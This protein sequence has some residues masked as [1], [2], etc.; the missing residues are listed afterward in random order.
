MDYLTQYYK[1]RS[2]QLQEEL[3]KLNENIFDDAY[4]LYQY[5]FNSQ[6]NQM[7][8]RVPYGTIDRPGRKPTKVPFK[9]PVL[10]GPDGIRPMYPPGLDPGTDNG[11]NEPQWYPGPDVGGQPHGPGPYPYYYNPDGSISTYEVRP[12]RR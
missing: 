4:Q 11:K 12:E 5:L 9:R 10:S 7:R 3:N 6:P 8:N 1:T 2:E